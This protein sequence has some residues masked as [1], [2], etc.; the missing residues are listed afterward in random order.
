MLVLLLLGLF[1]LL[2]LLLI[3]PV[4]AQT[5]DPTES[6]K[7]IQSLVQPTLQKATDWGYRVCVRIVGIYAMYALVIRLIRVGD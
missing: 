6:I 1:W 7:A 4:K 5:V 3:E 2:D